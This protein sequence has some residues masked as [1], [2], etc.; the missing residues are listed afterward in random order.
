MKASPAPIVPTASTGTGAAGAVT[1]AA[2]GTDAV[3]PC[4]PRS[5]TTGRPPPATQAPQGR[6]GQA[7]HPAGARRTSITRRSGEWRR[8][9]LWSGFESNAAPNVT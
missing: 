7:P 6:A 4:S 9:V 8:V 2:D 5:M 1:G 3:L